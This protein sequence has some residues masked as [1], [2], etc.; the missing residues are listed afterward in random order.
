MSASVAPRLNCYVTP[1]QRWFLPA[2]HTAALLAGRGV[3]DQSG[4]EAGRQ[5]TLTPGPQGGGAVL[6]SGDIQPVT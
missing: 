1:P 5:A 4:A 6:Y 3:I 2:R